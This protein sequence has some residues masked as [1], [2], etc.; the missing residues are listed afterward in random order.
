M[1]R[2]RYAWSIVHAMLAGA[3]AGAAGASVPTVADCLEASEFIANA[4]L[5]RDNGMTRDEFL[6]RMDQDF[7]AIKA[8][9]PSLRWFVQDNDDERFL[10]DSAREVFDH[11]DRSERH[12]AHF[13]HD[14]FER[15]GT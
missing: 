1:G 15:M 6:S 14:C 4:A 9:P 13:L 10:L 5:S 2:T 11:P 3:L 12:R 7:E 8:F